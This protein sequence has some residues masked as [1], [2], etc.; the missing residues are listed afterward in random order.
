MT[1]IVTANSNQC[2]I[3]QLGKNVDNATLI[4]EINHAENKLKKGDHLTSDK[5]G[6][7][8]TDGAAGGSYSPHTDPKTVEVA[9][10]ARE[11]AHE[12]NSGRTAN[13][14]Q[15]LVIITSPHMNG[16][17]HQHLDKHVKALIINEIQK[18]VMPLSPHELIDFLKK[19]KVHDA[20]NF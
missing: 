6:R 17:L 13:A 2:C 14:Y 5:P 4:K 7:Y 15:H 10:F 9:N 18:D 8:Q 20:N 19:N 12:L 1:W 11:I 16:L 3:Y